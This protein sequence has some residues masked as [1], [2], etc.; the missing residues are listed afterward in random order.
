MNLNLHPPKNWDEFQNLCHDLWHLM[1]ND[2]NTQ[3]NGRQGYNQCSVDIFGFPYY[4]KAYHGVQCK[5]RN[6]NYN[7]KLTIGEVDAE[8]NDA[9]AHFSPGLEALVGA[10]TSPRDPKI[11]EYCRNL[12][13]S[14]TY[15]YLRKLFQDC[16]ISLSVW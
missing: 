1:W 10:T 3:L 12:S 7:S 6:A 13:I 8:C 9:E 15:K 4:A 2:P 16:P 11:Q 5:G 14:H